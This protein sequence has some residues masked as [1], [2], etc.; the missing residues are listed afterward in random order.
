[1][2]KFMVAYTRI[3]LKASRMVVCMECTISFRLPTGYIEWDFSP[4]TTEEA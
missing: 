4:L 1:M 3:P 2:A